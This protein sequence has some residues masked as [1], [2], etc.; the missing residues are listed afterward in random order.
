MD[1]IFES[2]ASL[3]KRKIIVM[4]YRTLHVVLLSAVVHYLSC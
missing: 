3:V 2:T 1:V 4:I